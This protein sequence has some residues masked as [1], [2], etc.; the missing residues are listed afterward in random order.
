[1][2]RRRT[3]LIAGL[4]GAAAL[5]GVAGCNGSAT[6]HSM[7][8][9][10]QDFSATEAPAQ[11]ID[12]DEAYYWLDDQKRLNVA[13]CRH[14]PSLLGKAY[15]YDWR[16]SLVLED[17]PA[18]SEKLYRLGVDSIRLLLAHGGLHAR[19]ASL[20]GVAVVHAPR[21]GV[22]R[23]RFHANL[24]QQAF[25]VLT[26]WT[27]PLGRAPLVVMAGPFQ[28]IHDPVRGRAIRDRTEADGMERRWRSQTGA[29]GAFPIYPA[30]T[31]AASQPT[32]SSTRPA[33]PFLPVR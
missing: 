33:A 5:C 27:P 2:I 6:V 24:R 28:A 8:F 1:M 13:L 18:G 11:K 14:V 23:G 16:L 31:Q 7:P 10:R 22:M 4:I 20:M 21:N 17:L 30:T 32:L 12:I 25:T 15:E 3:S 26:G 19:G 9:L 29:A